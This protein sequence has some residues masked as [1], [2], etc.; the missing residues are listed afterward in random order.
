MKSRAPYFGSQVAGRR[1]AGLRA[2]SSRGSGSRFLCSVRT[3]APANRRR[4]RAV[5]RAKVRS[6]P[7]PDEYALAPHVGSTLFPKLPR[8]DTNAFLC[9]L[10]AGL[11][12]VVALAVARFYPLAVLVS[13]VLLPVMFFFYMYATRLRVEAGARGHAHDRLGCDRRHRASGFSRA[14]LLSTLSFGFAHLADADVFKR[15]FILPIAAFIATIVAIVV[16]Y[17]APHYDELLD[18]IAFGATTAYTMPPRKRSL[19]PPPFF[20]TNFSGRGLLG[21]AHASDRGHVARTD[22]VGRGCTL[23]AGALWLGGRCRSVT[24]GGGQIGTSLRSAGILLFVA[25]EFVLQGLRRGATSR[26]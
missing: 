7:R 5:R 11:V 25:P 9:V 3:S 6:P 14:T 23:M 2:L 1:V 4:G 18:G 21:V 16:L 13:A 17:L 26:R 22:F 24:S 10:T 12:V 20:T 15:V 19:R 8:R